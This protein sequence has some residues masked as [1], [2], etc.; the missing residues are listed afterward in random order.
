MKQAERLALAG[1]PAR[2][3]REAAQRKHAATKLALGS[4]PP[5]STEERLAQMEQLA[6]TMT[7]ALLKSEAKVTA[8][9]KR[10]YALAV[11][12][13]LAIPVVKRAR[14][15]KRRTQRI[16]DLEGEVAFL[17]KQKGIDVPV[18][19]VHG[20]SDAGKVG[21]SVGGSEKTEVK[22]YRL[23]VSIASGSPDAVTKA[24]QLGAT[25]KTMPA[26]DGATLTATSHR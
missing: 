24:A 15:E 11:D 22:F 5:E 1:A 20:V 18:L 4:A 23:T 26:A 21:V 13:S 6:R 10:Y 14:I 2:H 19:R 17:R 16:G 9:T 25:F 8:L 7:A 3:K 12:Q